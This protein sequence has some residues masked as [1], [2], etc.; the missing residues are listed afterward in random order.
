MSQRRFIELSAGL[1]DGDTLTEARR[2]ADA[3]IEHAKEP[4]PPRFAKPRRSLYP[5][6]DAHI[7][8]L[9]EP[10]ST[11]FRFI[12]EG[13][14]VGYY[15]EGKIPN[16]RRR[17]AYRLYKAQ[18]QEV[19][20]VVGL[21]LPLRAS[22]QHPLWIETV[23]Y[24]ANGVHADPEN[25]H[26]GVKDALFWQPKIPGVKRKGGGDKYTGGSYAPPKYD[27]EHPRVEI[28]IKEM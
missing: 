11:E 17:S 24:F 6:S 18:I 21:R 9:R 28:L 14:P 23:A 7:A 26:K 15:S 20:A 16:R 3:H 13:P 12:V 19:A 27:A 25:V 1:G 22:R 10:P 8:R 5:E 4:P 2:L